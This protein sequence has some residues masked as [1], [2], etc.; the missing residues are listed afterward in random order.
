M[1]RTDVHQ[2]L[3]PEALV[4]GLARRDT[5]PRLYRSG[6][7]WALELAGEPPG[8]IDLPAQ[9]GPEER[10]GRLDRDEID[11]ALIAPSTPLG[12]EA[13]PPEEAAPLL[14]AFN[15][16]VLELGE[17]FRLWATLPEGA[18]PAALDALLD[19]GAI[20]LCLS[21]RR[22]GS[23]AAL[24][25][26]APLLTRLAARRA[27]LLVHPGPA[28]ASRHGVPSWWPAMTAY[29]A[30]MQAAWLA[31][32]AWGRV[33]H[34]RLTVVWA[35]LAGGAPLHA[36]RL[37]ARGGPASAVSDPRSLYDVSSYGH[38]AI[39]AMLRT[40]GVDRLLYGT[41]TPVVDP[42]DLSRLGPAVR[43]AL[44]ET[45]PASLVPTPLV[46]A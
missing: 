35:M 19:A 26:H 9:S 1:P 40:V 22:L 32:A 7:R 4:A 24:A 38:K 46:P 45:N 17:R 43:H 11:V 23:P 37:A 13:L 39:D 14:G 36:E 6:A 8:E 2:H 20:G 27:P 28:P 10:I 15:H 34:P 16:G 18:G 30:E 33:V 29:I 3:W 21:G 5:A 25:A 41:D 12:I 44:A 42:P 31:F